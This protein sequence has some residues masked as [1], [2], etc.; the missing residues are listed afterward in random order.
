MDVRNAK[1][2]LSRA[3]STVITLPALGKEA[4]LGREQFDGLIGPVLRPTT[5]LAKSLIQNTAAAGAQGPPTAVVL[6][7]GASRIPLVATLLARATGIAPIVIEQPE[8]VVAEGAL[9]LPPVPAA[10]PVPDAVPGGPHAAADGASSDESRTPPASVR[11][12]EQVEVLL[13]R[14]VAERTGEPDGNDEP[15]PLL[16]ETDL[17]VRGHDDRPTRPG[18]AGARTEPHADAP[19]GPT[20]RR[21]R[22]PLNLARS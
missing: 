17:E 5:A 14:A 20:R 18:D 22:S 21:L 3:S 7:G 11:L 8:L 4:P 6:V 10:G 2:M 9:H 15:D 12:A 16:D 13:R 19:M 1:E